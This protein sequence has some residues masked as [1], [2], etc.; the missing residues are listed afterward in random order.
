M[1]YVGFYSGYPDYYGTLVDNKDG[2]YTI[3]YNVDKSGMYVMRIAMQEEGLNAT[4]FNGTNLGYLYDKSSYNSEEYKLNLQGKPVNY[5]LAISWTGDLGGKITSSGGLGNTSSYRDHYRSRMEPIVNVS[6]TN[7]IQSYLN[8]SHGKRF[9]FREQYWSARWT[10]MITPKFAEIYKIVVEIDDDSTA[11]LWIGGIGVQTNRSYLGEHVL[12]VSL[13][14]RLTTGYYNFTDVRYREFLLEFAHFTGDAQLRL[15][16]ESLSTPYSMIPATA[17]S[18]WR[19]ISH[20]NVTIHPN[21]GLLCSRCSTAFGTSLTKARVN[22]EQSFTIYGRDRFNNLVQRGGDVPSMV[23]IG[24]DG[25]AFRGKVTDYGNS[26]YLFKYF[27]TQAGTFKM[28]VTIGCC[29][30]NPAGGYPNEIELIQPLLIQGAPFTLHI[31]SAPLNP[32]RSV[33][34]GNGVVGGIAGEKRVF[35]VVYRDIFNNPTVTLDASNVK[36]IVRFLEATTNNIEPPDFYEVTTRSADNITISYIHNK[37]GR[38]KVHISVDYSENAKA[39]SNPME[40][41]SSPFDVVISPAEPEYKEM[42]VRGVGMRYAAVQ[43]VADAMFEIQL[44]DRFKNT[45]IV[46]GDKFYV[47]LNGDA[48][49]SHP[50]LPVVPKC[51]DTQNGRY[52][53]TYRPKY[54]RKHELVVKLLQNSRTHPGGNGLL[55]QYFTTIDGATRGLGDLPMFSKVDAMIKLGWK[56]GYYIP[57]TDYRT[58]IE[59]GKPIPHTNI[60]TA[61]PQSIRWSGYLVAPR[62]DEFFITAI[63]SNLHV[64]IFLD[65]L[66][67]YDNSPSPTNASAPIVAKSVN[68][69][70]DAA[71]EIRIESKIFNDVAVNQDLVTIDLIWSTA[72]V[73]PHSISTFFLYDRAYEATLSP[74]PVTVDLV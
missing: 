21:T 47:R 35:T 71:Y 56:D 66:L 73:K 23:A 40:I 27:P 18:H 14:N 57:Y 15:Y 17:F 38:Y 39:P 24:R 70:T 8:S 4:Y 46:G 64:S 58:V 34:I 7:G 60:V 63:T 19:N 30:P 5:G 52:R 22:E 68:M 48:N 44:Y 49:Y 50:A 36:V 25:V 28:Y 16:W 9:N 13:N 42:I 65:E 3:E 41:L 29:A 10:G 33:A 37:A 53:C 59:L 67:I 54:S 26:T 55:G 51:V 45:L 11:N 69:L 32:S 1:E 74:F 31:D 62:T 43:A 20:Y 2:T 72:N 12:N 6:N 61:V